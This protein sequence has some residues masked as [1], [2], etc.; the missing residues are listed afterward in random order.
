MKRAEAQPPGRQ[1][2]TRH[3]GLRQPSSPRPAWQPQPGSD[4]PAPL[5]PGTRAWLQGPQRAG[6]PGRLLSRAR[7]KM[8]A[9]VRTGARARAHV[10]TCALARRR[11]CVPASMH[12]GMRARGRVGGQAGGRAGACMY[13][14]AYAVRTYL[15]TYLP[16]YLHTYI[17]TRAN[18]GSRHR[19]TGP[20]LDPEGLDAECTG[21]RRAR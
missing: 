7:E 12:A 8:H 1:R 9:R 15:L 11:A 5:T 10:G 13:G 4:G 18:N 2:G 17:Y 19:W 6:R 14:H 3:G 21:P 16:T 20:G